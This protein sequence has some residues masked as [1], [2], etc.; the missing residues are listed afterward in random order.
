MMEVVSAILEEIMVSLSSP[1]VLFL[2]LMFSLTLV[3]LLYLLRTLPE[4]F[5]KMSVDEVVK[6]YVRWVTLT[7]ETP[8]HDRLLKSYEEVVLK[9]WKM[10]DR[11]VK[12]FLLIFC[13]IPFIFVPILLIYMV[14]IVGIETS[15][16]I[17]ETLRGLIPSYIGLIFIIVLVALSRVLMR[18]QRDLVLQKLCEIEK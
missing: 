15:F 3:F 2:F 9:S 7:T 18:K 11:K 6:K 8:S 17:R 5:K 4:K 16:F 13:I 14:S 10:S 12:Y 1:E